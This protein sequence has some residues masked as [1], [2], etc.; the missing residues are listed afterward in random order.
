MVPFKRLHELCRGIIIR[1]VEPEAMRDRSRYTL[2]QTER[3]STDEICT[4]RVR[5]IQRVEEKWSGWTE[6]I[7]DMLLEGIDHFA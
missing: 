1:D 6:E 7:L 2:T 4:F 3:V 5:V